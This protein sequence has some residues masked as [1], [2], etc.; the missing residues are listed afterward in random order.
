MWNALKKR[1]LRKLIKKRK[2]DMVFVQETKL[3][4]LEHIDIQR[5]W[6]KNNVEFVSSNSVGA[7]GGF[8]FYGIVHFFRF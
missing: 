1:L 3:E 5:L 6:G 2:S 8:L 7:S 4:L